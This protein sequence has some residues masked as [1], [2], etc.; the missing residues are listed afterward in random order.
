ALSPAINDPTTGVISIDQLHRLLRS[1]G[2]RHLRTDRLVNDAG[3]LRAIVRT[4]NWEDFLH[5]SFREIRSCGSN[6]LQIVR[7]LRGMIE[8]L[9]DTLPAH[10]HPALLQE[11]EL[12]DRDIDRH[13][14]YPEDAALAHI[15]DSQGLGGH[16]S[17]SN[18]YSKRI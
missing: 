14:P 7:R 1:V 13:F 4:P 5:L 18:S 9:L 11:L 12:L 2:K 16:S 15:A 3:Q 10:R 8:N 6:S 17:K